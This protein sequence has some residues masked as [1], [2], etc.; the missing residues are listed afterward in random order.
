MPDPE[1]RGSLRLS[2]LGAATPLLAE[3]LPGEISIRRL[4]ADLGASARPPRWFSL[5]PYDLDTRAMDTLVSRSRPDGDV[6][7]ECPDAD[8]ARRFLGRLTGSAPVV[9]LRY[10]KP[11]RPGRIAAGRPWETRLEDLTGRRLA[12]HDS[13]LEAAQRLPSARFAAMV[14]GSRTVDDLTEQ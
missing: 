7:V 10:R 4:S 9:V 13:I 5:L 14:A 1:A 12:L 8:Q 6:V 3:V 11:H 2:G